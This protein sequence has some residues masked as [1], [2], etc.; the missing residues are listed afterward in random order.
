MTYFL[1]SQSKAMETNISIFSEDLFEPHVFLKKFEKR[2]SRLIKSEKS[3][4][5]PAVKTPLRRLVTVAITIIVLM[6]VM[7][8][9][10]SAFRDAFIGFIARIFDTHTE[11][12]TI[13]DGNAPS[14]IE[15]VYTITAPEDFELVYAD[16]VLTNQLCCSFSYVNNNEYVIF[17]QFVKSEYDVNVNTENNSTEYIEINGY[18]GYIIDLGNDEYFISWD[19]GDYVFDIT[20]SIIKDALIKAAKTVQKVE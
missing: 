16:D 1:K 9:S 10:V 7:T 8:V 4:Y 14:S 5:F 17:T 19:N 6:S 20:G 15:D 18:D 3:F 12:R 11:V 2:M 13:D